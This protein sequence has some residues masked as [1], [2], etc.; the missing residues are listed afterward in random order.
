VPIAA[1]K[2]TRLRP[3]ILAAG[4]FVSTLQYYLLDVMTQIDSLPRIVV[5]VPEKTGAPRS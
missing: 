2:G 3:I 4:L 5:F 1:I